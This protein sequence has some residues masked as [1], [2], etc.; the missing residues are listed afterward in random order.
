MVA[1][2]EQAFSQVRPNESGTAS[3]QIAQEAS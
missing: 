1:A 2:F 3:D